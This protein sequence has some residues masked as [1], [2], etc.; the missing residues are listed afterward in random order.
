VL[1][2]FVDIALNVTLVPEHIAP[3]GF[4][5][6]FTIAGKLELTVIVIEFEVA[7]LPDKQGLALEVKT[8]VIT[9][10]FASVA[11]VYVEFIAPEIFDPFFCH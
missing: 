3:E 10:K 7:G 9:S 6:I 8:H 11:D 1:P 5:A 2:P 4:A